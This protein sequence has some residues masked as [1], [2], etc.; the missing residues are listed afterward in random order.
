MDLILIWLESMAIAA[1][2][3]GD[4]AGLRYGIV[5]VGELVDPS[6]NTLSGLPGRVIVVGSELSHLVTERFVGVST[7]VFNDRQFVVERGTIESV[8]KIR[9]QL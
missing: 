3:L 8:P 1:A 7:E 6:H 4:R 9:V 5:A 2:R